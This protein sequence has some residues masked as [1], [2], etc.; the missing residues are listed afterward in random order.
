MVAEAYV[1]NPD[2]E[3]NTIVLHIDS[4]KENKHYTNLKWGTIS[5]N[6]K[7]AFDEGMAYNDRGWKDSQSIHVCQ[8]DL[9]GN[10]IK[11]FGSIGEA[12]RELDITKTTILNQCNHKVKTKPRCGFWFR[13]M[14][15]YDQKGFVL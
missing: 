6:T 1:P 4:N 10:L 11:R 2:P 8:F 5:E 3:H 15:E 13:Y 12:S 7:Q 14:S 9:H